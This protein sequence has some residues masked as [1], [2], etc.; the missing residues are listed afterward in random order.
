VEVAALANL[1]QHQVYQLPLVL[2]IQLRLGQVVMEVGQ[3]VGQVDTII[4]VEME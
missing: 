1:E 2:L 3:V 4:T